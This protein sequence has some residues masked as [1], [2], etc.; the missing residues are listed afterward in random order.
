MQGDDDTAN[1][2]TKRSQAWPL[3]EFYNVEVILGDWVNILYFSLPTDAFLR[4]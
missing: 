1:A 4:A 3:S 2:W